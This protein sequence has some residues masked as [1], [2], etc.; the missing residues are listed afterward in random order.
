MK[1]YWTGITDDHTIFG[2]TEASV[3]SEYWLGV[4]I[5]IA[6]SLSQL[7]GGEPNDAGAMEDGV[8]QGVDGLWNDTF[9]GIPE[10]PA[11]P[12]QVKLVSVVEWNLGASSAI[13]GA[14]I[15]KPVL[16]VVL[17]GPLGTAGEFGVLSMRGNG[18]QIGIRQA[19]ESIQSGGGTQLRGAAP[20]IN[21]VDPESPNRGLFLEDQIILANTAAVDNNTVHTYKGRVNVTT[22]GIYTFGIISDD[23]FALRVRAGTWSS[24][25]GGNLMIDSLSGG[26]TVFLDRNATG[27]P[28]FAQINLP[29]GQ[30][31]IDFV[32]MNEGGACGHE[33]FVAQGA[34]TNLEQTP[35][36][37]LLGQVSVGIIGRPGVQTGGFTVT[38]SA[39]NGPALNNL[40]N[41]MTQLTATGTVSTGYTTINF[42][43]PDSPGGGGSFSPSNPF[44]RD[45][46]GVDDD[47]FAVQVDATVT[48]P[49]E[50]DYIFGF[51]SDD[52]TALQ[53]PGKSWIGIVD[54]VNGN[55]VIA[56][57]TVM[58]NVNTG[59]SYTRA[60]I[61][62]TAGT[63]AMRGLYWEA[64]GGANYELFADSALNPQSRLLT[65]GA[66]TSYTD[67]G[68]LALVAR[69]KFALTP[70][71]FSPEYTLLLQWNTLPGD[72]Y[73]PEYSYDLINWYPLR[74]QPMMATGAT[75]SILMT[76]LQPFPRA[77][78]HVRTW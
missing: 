34:F 62:L 71:T 38:T 41:A 77:F 7:G 68:G 22:G 4:D 14:T 55:S 31:S 12:G 11:M 66:A 60:K 27:G 10:G 37:R 42:A 32:S 54:A 1:A 6:L 69:P 44:P 49:V 72:P 61:H 67:P 51:R 25:S 26:N 45:N 70:G 47:N 2:G 18:T 58:H 5:R 36:W 29:V 46:V 15:V 53:I 23:S 3:E 59:D 8:Y 65:V 48:I 63:Y 43:D 35:N 76:Q 13:P 24:V 52:G 40:A 9:S 64:G 78:Y 39:P 50:G 21:H 30:H 57:D 56:G 33:V 28:V 75:D 74:N 19:V 20:S 16:P 17:E 73:M